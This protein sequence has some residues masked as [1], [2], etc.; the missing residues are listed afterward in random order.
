MRINYDFKDDVVKDIVLLDGKHYSDTGMMWGELSSI[1]GIDID[2][3]SMYCDWYILD[4]GFYYFKTC[5]IFEE[6]FMSELAI[7]CNVKCVSFELAKNTVSYRYP[8]IG[9][10]SKLYR[11]KEKEY[12]FY[13]DFCFKYFDEYI[14]DFDKFR[15]MSLNVFGESKYNKLI[16]DIYGMMA[17][18]MFTGQR[19]RGAHNFLFECNSDGVALAPLCDNGWV[20]SYEY[21]YDSPFGNYCLL[22]TDMFTTNRKSMIDILKSEKMLYERFGNLLDVDVK[23]VLKRTLD[24]YM[25]VLDIGSRGRILRYMDNKKKAIDTTLKLSRKK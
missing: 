9:V 21:N 6:L 14:N 3:L 2:T 1:T 7:E 12:Y 24:K 17:F 5:C 11:V 10:M 22:E 16:D 25:I 4:D 19:D 15:S 8:T 20:F 13:R 23:E 18:D